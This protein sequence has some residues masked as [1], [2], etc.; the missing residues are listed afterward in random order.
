VKR[1]NDCYTTQFI[2]PSL[3]APLIRY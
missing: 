3:F 1:L 2:K